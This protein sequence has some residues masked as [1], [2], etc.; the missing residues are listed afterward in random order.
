MGEANVCVEAM[1]EEIADKSVV[2]YETSYYCQGGEGSYLCKSRTSDEI[3]A[4]QIATENDEKDEAIQKKCEDEME[5]GGLDR[6][7]KGSLVKN[8]HGVCTHGFGYSNYGIAYYGATDGSTAYRV[9]NNH[10]EGCVPE[11]DGNYASCESP[12]CHEL[13]LKLKRIRD[14]TPDMYKAQLKQLPP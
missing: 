8:I 9:C 14:H 3:M 10:A 7:C 4:E 13:K 12:S 11:H 5:R 1:M 2:N 6:F